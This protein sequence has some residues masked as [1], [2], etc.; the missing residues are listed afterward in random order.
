MNNV[1]N[2][3]NAY[4]LEKIDI[5]ERSLRKTRFIAVSAVVVAV[6]VFAKQSNLRYDVDKLSRKESGEA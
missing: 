2:A 5:L 1:D 4:T 3:L 6:I